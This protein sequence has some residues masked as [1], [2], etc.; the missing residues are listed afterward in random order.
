MAKIH[1]IPRSRGASISASPVPI[2]PS[3]TVGRRGSTS[4]DGFT[5]STDGPPAVCT[6]YTPGGNGRLSMMLSPVLKRSVI[7]SVRA[8]VG[9]I[10]FEGVAAI[11]PADYIAQK[12]AVRVRLD[13]QMPFAASEFFGVGRN[14]VVTLQADE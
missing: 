3:T 2:S 12:I 10:R 7:E 9:R 4:A 6:S 5:T 11:N 8:G 1:P 13:S 14:V